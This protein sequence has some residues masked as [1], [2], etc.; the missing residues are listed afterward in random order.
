MADADTTVV[1]E[2]EQG[3]LDPSPLVKL[4]HKQTGVLSQ[5]TKKRNAIMGLMHFEVNLHKVK[6]LYEEYQDLVSSYGD[7]HS[8]MRSIGDHRCCRVGVRAYS[9]PRT[10]RNH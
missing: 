1:S 3:D 7:A 4:K 2:K 6:T 5:V 8:S 9:F 10:S